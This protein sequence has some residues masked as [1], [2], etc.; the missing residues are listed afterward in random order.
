MDDRSPIFSLDDRTFSPRPG[1]L[2]ERAESLMRL[3]K[4][5]LD[6]QP[7]PVMDLEWTCER[8]QI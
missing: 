6:Q 3:R 4:A 7:R 1:L 2:T 8:A 5:F